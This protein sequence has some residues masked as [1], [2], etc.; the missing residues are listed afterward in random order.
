MLILSELTLFYFDCVCKHQISAGPIPNWADKVASQA[1]L[2]P[3][4]PPSTRTSKTSHTAD[5]DLDFDEAPEEYREPLT[6]T[7]HGKVSGYYLSLNAICSLRSGYRAFCPETKV[8][9]HR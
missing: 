5:P 1:Q 6:L 3:S 7:Q 9:P 4:A 2:K 8:Q